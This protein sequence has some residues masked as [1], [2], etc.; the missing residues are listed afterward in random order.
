MKKSDLED[1][2]IN[3]SVLIIDISDEISNKRAG[4]H[5]ETYVCLRIIDRV[6]LCQT[7]EK[8]KRAIPENDELISIFVKSV[9]TA[10]K[11]INR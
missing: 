7:K 6:N 10:Q 9:E 8:I 2:L 3:F 4:N 1:R 11:N 5:R